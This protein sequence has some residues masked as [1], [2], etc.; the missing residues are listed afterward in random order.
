MNRKGVNYDT[1]F[2]PGGTDSR[3]DFDSETAK[4]EMRVIADELHCTSVRISGGVP[5]R[6]SA[7]ARH[8]ADAGLE[9]WF[10][11]FPCDKTQ[12]ELI[13]FYLDCATRAEELR[14]AGAEVVLVLGCE[15]TL[16]IHGFIDGE[17]TYARINTLSTGGPAVWSKLGQISASLNGFLGEVAKRVRE[18]FGGKLSYSSGTWEQVDWTP[19]DYV[20]VD[21]YRD[22]NNKSTFRDD[23]RRQF[24]HGKPVVV[25][26]FGCCTYEGAG[27]RGGM[28]WA[29]VDFSGEEPV[30][31]ADYVRSEAEQVTYLRESLEVFE[32]LG[33]DGAFWFTFVNEKSVH[34]AGDPR[35]DLDMGSYSVVK[36]SPE[37]AWAPKEVFHA[38]AATYRDDA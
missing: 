7:A 12:E 4:R 9:V 10:A 3:P 32:E 25:T 35:R 18:V 30:L 21:A 19:F 26:E 6:L 36:T 31:D 2:F 22:A 20:G 23:V 38:L 24:S 13:P 37:G 5:E 17:D 34:R 33:V 1:G 27:D 16:F 29:I 8:A 14:L 15:M 11:P 28:G